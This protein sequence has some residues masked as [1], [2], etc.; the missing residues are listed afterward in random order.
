M[1]RVK[2][3]RFVAIIWAILFAQSVSATNWINVYQLN[4]SV[5]DEVEW[6]NKVKKLTDGQIVAAGA[7]HAS[8]TSPRRNFLVKID[9]LGA[10]TGKVYDFSSLGQEAKL[11]GFVES[12]NKLIFIGDWEKNGSLDDSGLLVTT[13]L[14]GVVEQVVD[15]PGV[16]DFKRILNT[17]A[18]GTYLVA[19]GFDNKYYLVKLGASFSPEWK[20]EIANTDESMHDF[21]EVP[22][23]GFLFASYNNIK[24]VNYD[25]SI[26]WQRGYSV[27]G[28]ALERFKLASLGNG[29]VVVVSKDQS[30]SPDRKTFFRI[31]NSGNVEWGVF[32]VGVDAD[33]LIPNSVYGD[34][35]YFV[36]TTPEKGDDNLYHKTLSQMNDAGDIIWTKQFSNCNFR[37]LIGGNSFI[38]SS[39]GAQFV[40]RTLDGRIVSMKTETSGYACNLLSDYQVGS[41][42]V[43][44]STNTLSVTSSS[45]SSVSSVQLGT[46]VSVADLVFYES[47]VCGDIEP[48]LEVTFPNGGEE[49]VKSHYYDLKWNSSSVNSHVNIDLRKG[50]VQVERLAENVP[51]TGSHPFN[52]KEA[53]DVGGDYQIRVTSMSGQI[54]DTSDGNFAIKEELGAMPAKFIFSAVNSP[55]TVGVPFEVTVSAVDENDN[56]VTGYNGI[57][58]LATDI[59]PVSPMMA[60]CNDG[61]VTVSL[62]VFNGGDGVELWA[63]AYGV[64]GQSNVFSV[65]GNDNCSGQVTINGRLFDSGG[66]PI[67]VAEIS[68]TD[69]NGFSRYTNIVALGSFSFNNVDCGD[70]VLKCIKNGSS[71][72]RNIQVRNTQLFV[73]VGNLYLFVQTVTQDTPVIL[74]PG[75]MGSSARWNSIYPILPRRDNPDATLLHIHDPLGKTGFTDLEKSLK[76]EGFVV[77]D[78]AWNWRGKAK[79]AQ[80]YLT[81]SI[82]TA[83]GIVASSGVVSSG[84]VH[85]IAHSMGGLVAR[86][87]IQGDASYAAKIDKFVMVGTPNLGSPL[88]YYIWEGGDPKKADNIQEGLDPFKIFLNYYTNSTKNLWEKTYGMKNWSHKNHAAIGIFARDK[89]PALLDLMSIENFLQPETGGAVGAHQRSFNY[90]LWNLNNDSNVNRMSPSGAGG[91]IQ[92][93]LFIAGG[94]VDADNNT[95]QTIEIGEEDDLYIMGK[96]TSYVPGVGDGTVPYSSALWPSIDGWADLERW[97]S[98]KEHA[99]LIA[100]YHT[101]IIDFIKG[102]QTAF[103]GPRFKNWAIASAFRFNPFQVRTAYA[104]VPAASTSL[105]SFSTNGAVRITVTDPSG[106]V[107]G[108][109]ASGAVFRNIPSSDVIFG[110]DGGGID[111][112]DPQAGTYSVSVF[113]SPSS[114]DFGV[115]VGFMDENETKTLDL[116]GVYTNNPFYFTVDIVSGQDLVVLPGTNGMSAPTIL[117]AD[118]CGSLTCLSWTAQTGVDHFNV[119]AA[120]KT[121]PFYTKVTELS[122]TSTSFATG[123]RWSGD[124]MTVPTIFAISA[125]DSGGTESFLSNVTVNNDQDHDGISDVEERVRGTNPA[126]TDTDGDGLDD[127]EETFKLETSP[128]LSDTDGDGISDYEEIHGQTGIAPE[129]PWWEG[130]LLV[131]PGSDSEAQIQTLIDY[132]VAG[133]TLHAK[134]STLKQGGSVDHTGITTAAELPWWEWMLLVKPTSDSQV[135]MQTLLNYCEYDSELYH[136]IKAL[137]Q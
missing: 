119:Y 125:V 83:L 11:K 58:N 89:A 91:T 107:S 109:N 117:K 103:F 128:L 33:I 133:S 84:K 9:P 3:L 5:F 100:D 29:D 1:E 21:C 40:G 6:L 27:N 26:G 18:N 114:K 15:F 93:A 65:S 101:E 131:K 39:E 57:V 113:G 135:Q 137:M 130:M 102:N 7:L 126:L 123:E 23:E 54:S 98:Q 45:V 73:D 22:G 47:S 50:G 108:M 96:P 19:K 64:Q 24:R 74:I 76:S 97:T 92:T 105:L 70:Y 104:T 87:L 110:D 72:V 112:E 53:L 52:P 134:L 77:V 49:F 124:V 35:I 44:V 85:I 99:E 43:N 37:P 120:K 13:T 25:G 4:D 66:S 38:E 17:N 51:N 28:V 118:P 132:C 20:R 121:E 48:S 111:I 75:I 32:L 90:W 14:T 10:V 115:T 41:S 56:I 2:V 8:A 36:S 80:S 81:Y 136:K 60:H 16:S 46:N 55:Q 106:N 63:D 59:G 116:D 61:Q 129:F 82:D 42:T 69:V 68:L 78:C 79:D 127:Y 34:S 31:N 95:I 122:G 86:S 71:L 88:P 12:N 62:E 30:V 94:H 67:D